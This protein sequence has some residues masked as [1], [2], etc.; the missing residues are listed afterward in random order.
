MIDRY[1]PAYKTRAQ[2]R[3][4]YQEERTFTEAVL[5]GMKQRRFSDYDERCYHG[6]TYYRIAGIECFLED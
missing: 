4:D 6:E 1:D 3:H 2:M 5:T